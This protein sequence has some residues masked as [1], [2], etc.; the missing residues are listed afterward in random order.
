M[1]RF[2]PAIDPKAVRS[3][4]L[5]VSQHGHVEKVADGRIW[6]GSDSETAA[7]F[8]TTWYLYP[9][10]QVRLSFLSPSI[11]MQLWLRHYDVQEF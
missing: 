4:A 2:I 6:A 7:D 8:T 1:H 5:V 9:V 10:K 11:P 3:Q